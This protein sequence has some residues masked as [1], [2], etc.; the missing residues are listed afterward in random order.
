M[1]AIIGEIEAPGNIIR[2]V[3]PLKVTDASGKLTKDEETAR[4]IAVVSVIAGNY[5]IAGKINVLLH[6][7]SGFIIGRMGM[8]YDGGRTHIITATFDA[9]ASE[10]RTL[11]G[12]L[13]I[14]P[15]VCVKATYAPAVFPKEE[16]P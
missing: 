7:Y 11:V 16:T 13:S 12:K 8:P 3:L 9:P 5:E 10:I 14:L 1:K 6:E 2:D 4:C 15:D